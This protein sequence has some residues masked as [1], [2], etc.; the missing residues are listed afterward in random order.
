MEMMEIQETVSDHSYSLTVA[1][2]RGSFVIINLRDRD[3]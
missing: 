2:M 3:S 1:S